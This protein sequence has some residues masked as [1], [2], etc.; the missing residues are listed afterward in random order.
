MKN[1]KT[2]T[3]IEL[4]TEWGYLFAEDSLSNY[5]IAKTDSLFWIPLP[6]LR[7]WAVG[8]TAQGGAD[9]FRRTLYMDVA[10]QISYVLH[11]ENVPE[12]ITVYVNGHN[13]GQADGKRALVKDISAHLITGQNIVAIKV[14][15]HSRRSGGVFGAVYLQPMLRGA[16][17]CV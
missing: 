13:I 10:T 9:W 11:I 6:D 16:D 12:F 3:K 4:N 15:P 14:L 2:L 7:D 1:M 17:G 8:I 5:S